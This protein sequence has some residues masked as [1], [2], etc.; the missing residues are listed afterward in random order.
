M[1]GFENNRE[2]FYSQ[3]PG[4]SEAADAGIALQAKVDALKAQLAPMHKQFQKLYDEGIATEVAMEK[5]GDTQDEIDAYALNDTKLNTLHREITALDEEL[6][7][8]YMEMGVE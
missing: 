4:Y 5:Q 8:L 1:N 3:V 2:S 6:R 7:A